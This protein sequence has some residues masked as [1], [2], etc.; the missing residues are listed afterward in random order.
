MYFT[1]V[2]I[3]SLAAVVFGNGFSLSQLHCAKGGCG[4]YSC[5]C[6]EYK[7]VLCACVSCS[8]QLKKTK[9]KGVNVVILEILKF[10]ISAHLIFVIIASCTSHSSVVHTNHNFMFLCD[11]QFLVLKFIANFLFLQ[12][13]RSLSDAMCF[14]LFR[15]SDSFERSLNSD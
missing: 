6:W 4:F 8:F 13:S 3:V 7:V 12:I 11:Y 10:L 1:L 5:S 2:R 15:S 9:C 14:I